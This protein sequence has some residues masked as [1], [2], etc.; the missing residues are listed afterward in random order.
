MEDSEQSHSVSSGTVPD[1]QDL[2]R[3]I[4]LSST[5][6]PSTLAGGTRKSQPLPK[7]TKT[8]PKDS[9]GNKQ[10]IDKGLPSM[11]SDEDV[12]A[13]LLYD[14][15]AQESKEKILGASEEMD[16]NPQSAKIQH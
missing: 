6:L 11:D 1:P 14:D 15:E 7:G 3:D 5:R 10:P 13:F 4:Q 12:R 16:K 8:N 9:V 2:E